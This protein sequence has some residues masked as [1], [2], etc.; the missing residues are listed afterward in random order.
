LHVSALVQ[1][2]R[3]RKAARVDESSEQPLDT[4][5][6]RSEADEP[7]KLSLAANAAAVAAAADK[8]QSRGAAGAAPPLFGDDDGRWAAE[9]MQLP[10]S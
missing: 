4:E 3:A 7:I 10:S 8:Q 9:V 1:V 2:E 5:L 6:K